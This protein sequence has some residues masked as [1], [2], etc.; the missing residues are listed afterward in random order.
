M[1]LRFWRWR[2]RGH[3]RSGSAGGSSAG[4]GSAGGGITAAAL[5]AV[6]SAVVLDSICSAAKVSAG[7]A[8]VGRPGQH[9]I[10]CYITTS[11]TR[12]RWTEWP[13]HCGSCCVPPSRSA[14]RCVHTPGNLQ[15][16]LLGH[17]E[18]DHLQRPDL[19]QDGQCRRRRRA[20]GGGTYFPRLPAPHHLPWCSPLPLHRPSARLRLLLL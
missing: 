3:R 13:R 18:D 8:M 11:M 4:A 20:M 17:Q 1:S 5:A 7:G 12:P 19:K 9:L 14:K 2:Q 16:E 15:Q 10:C 6:A